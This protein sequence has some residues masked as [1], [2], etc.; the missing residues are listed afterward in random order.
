MATFKKRIEYIASTLEHPARFT[1]SNLPYT[2]E[3]GDVFTYETEFKYIVN[4]DTNFASWEGYVAHAGYYWY[5]A[6]NSTDLKLGPNATTL[7]SLSTSNYQTLKLER[8]KASG[9]N[10]YING[11]LVGTRTDGFGLLSEK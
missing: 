2:G 9:V 8:D 1:I 11:T 7:A 4:T 10:C 6:P 5:V 3:T